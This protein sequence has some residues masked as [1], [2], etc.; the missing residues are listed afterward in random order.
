[1]V[2]A[3]LSALAET[4]V[5]TLLKDVNDGMSWHILSSP[6]ASCINTMAMACITISSLANST[7][8]AALAPVKR[9]ALSARWTVCRRHAEDTIAEDDDEWF[10]RDGMGD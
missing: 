1:M 5:L 3:L 7:S 2:M 4:E 6:V 9:T 8:V 10:G